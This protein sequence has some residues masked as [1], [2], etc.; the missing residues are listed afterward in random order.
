MDKDTCYFYDGKSEGNILIVGKTR[1]GKTTFVQN[2]AKNKIFGSIKEVY[3][4]SKISLSRDRE[5]NIVDAFDKHV[6]FKYPK[7]LEEFDTLFDFFQRKREKNNCNETY[8]RE[9]MLLDNLIVMDDVSDLA[10]ISENFP[11]FLTVSRK[12]GLT[13]IY[14]TLLENTTGK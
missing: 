11:N 10:D 7:N 13:C 8:M 9:N 6:E 2:L 5:E 14:S 3:W 12:F 1:L 4:L